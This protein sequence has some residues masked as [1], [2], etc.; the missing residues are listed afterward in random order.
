MRISRDKEGAG[1]GV[2]R[3]ETECRALAG[4]LGVA[5]ADVYADNDLSAYS[6]KPRPE[7][8]RLL[9]DV[10]AG[11]VDVV[12]CWHTDRLHRSVI[13]LEEWISGCEQHGV[14]VHTVAAG[15]LDLSTWAAVMNA[16]LHAVIARGE[17]DRTRARVRSAKAQAAAAGKWRGGPRPF[18]FEADGV[19]VRPAEADVVDEATRRVLAGE[20]LHS[21]C[22]DLDRRGVT[23]SRGPCG[24]S[25]RKPCAASTAGRAC[26][27]GR[28]KPH[29]LRT[30]LLRP[31]NAALI[32]HDGKEVGPAGWPAIVEPARWRNLRRLLTTDGR[33]PARSTDQK[34]LGAGLYLCGVCDDGTTMKSA[35]AS[36]RRRSDGAVMPTYVCRGGPHLA[37]ASAPLDAFVTALVIERLSRPDARLLLAPENRRIDVE[38]LHARRADVDAKLLEIAALYADGAVSGPQLAES[39]RRLR[40][41]AEEIDGEIAAAS[42]HS[43]LAGFADA[44]DVVS[45]WAAATVGRRKAIVRALMSVT[46]LPAARQGGRPPGWRPGMP[47]FDPDAV[48]V[49]PAGAN[50][51]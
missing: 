20:T 44:D 5:V 33:R 8:R 35:S 50:R 42:V 3:Q 24:T 15:P 43:P 26:S 41:E 32:E 29:A 30:M 10:Q 38:T 31:R 17:V 9:A 45:A 6:G 25:D 37:R 12:L 19:T 46:V 28:W 4:R 27:C 22:R 16:R 1:L 36:R 11:R 40:A 14:T 2:E 39:T 34:W 23:T 7:Y 48:L 47:Y 13:E 49:R 18:G 21:V 51:T